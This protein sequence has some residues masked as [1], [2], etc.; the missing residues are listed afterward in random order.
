MKLIIGLGNPEEKYSHT[1]HNVGFSFIDAGEKLQEVV[2][3]KVKLLKSKS[4][5]NNSGDFVASEVNK[6][7][8]DWEKAGELGVNIIIVHDDLDIPLGQFKIQRG[9]GPKVHNGILSVEE[10]LGITDFYRVRI[11]VDARDPSLRTPGE[12]YVLQNFTDQ[13]EQV[14]SSLFPVIWQELQQKLGS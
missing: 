8:G 10:K 14:L 4:F 1:R 7:R 9:V 2:G 13:E 5:M 11:G 3:N 6:Y 12:T